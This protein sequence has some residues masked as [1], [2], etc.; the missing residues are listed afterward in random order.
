MTQTVCGAWQLN[1]TSTTP[2]ISLA[3]IP[4]SEE[5]SPLCVRKIDS[6]QPITSI[7]S[8]SRILIT[9]TGVRRKNKGK[10]RRRNQVNKKRQ[11]LRWKQRKNKKSEKVGFTNKRQGRSVGQAEDRQAAQGC[12]PIEVSR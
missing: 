5:R 6:A 10:G 3:E 11:S 12:D 7:I 1:T 2:D 9:G 8:N 4:C